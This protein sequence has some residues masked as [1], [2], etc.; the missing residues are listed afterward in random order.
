MTNQYLSRVQE[1]FERAIEMDSQ[2]RTVFLRKLE[3]TDPQNAKE[4]ES[5]FQFHNR[6]LD[7]LEVTCDH[8]RTLVQRSL[9]EE[10]DE[11]TFPIIEGYI[12]ERHIGSGGQADVYLAT[13]VSTGQAVAVKIFRG[14]ALSDAQ[15]SRIDG[16]T[17]ALVQLQL[18]N[19]V[20]ILDRGEVATGQEYLVTRYIDGVAIDEAARK[21]A[22]E[23]PQE[24]LALF[25]R[26]AETLALVH[27][28]GIVHRDLKPS[29]ILVDSNNQPYLLDFGLARFFADPSGRLLTAASV[30]GFQGSMLWAS[31][32]QLD[33]SFGEIDQRSDLYSLGV[34]IYQSITGSFPYPVEGGILG[35]AQNIVK[36]RAMAL[37]H[38]DL[39]DSRIG[40]ALSK[41]VLRLLEKRQN[42]RFQSANELASALNSLLR[43]SSEGPQPGSSVAAA[44]SWTRRNVIYVTAGAA[45]A[46]V[47]VPAIHILDTSSGD[48]LPDDTPSDSVSR[49][50]DELSEFGIV[51][52]NWVQ[53]GTLETNQH[54]IAR[55][56]LS[57][58][59]DFTFKISVS[60]IREKKSKLT[61]TLIGVKG[62][63]DV[64]ISMSKTNTW[65]DNE[66]WVFTLP[67]G[68]YR[69]SLPIQSHT[70]I[71]SRER[72]LYRLTT[73]AAY[74]SNDLVIGEFA[75][76]SKDEFGEIRLASSGRSLVL[77]RATLTPK[78]GN[79]QNE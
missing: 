33:T 72:D 47:A 52:S 43:Q 3:S 1:L 77:E 60:S 42:R 44:Q 74:R 59:K 26:V 29:N 6:E 11:S 71:F 61:V 21:L 73:D 54:E 20:P 24:F 19:V 75:G 70:F 65:S 40:A 32:E 37:P 36:T 39:P 30:D 66:N 46:L 31:P 35:I 12:V 25:I 7:P 67:S 53:V 63:N 27:Q 17:R 5:L 79:N 34:V 48:S 51:P 55:E 41:V 15:R 8:R 78:S 62:A 13:Q 9:Q 22:V 50:D 14:L 16:E 45:M 57:I 49:F 10:S 76:N 68:A 64:R 4:L 58:K 38:G 56:P 23:E 18:P 28:Q 2:A 69:K